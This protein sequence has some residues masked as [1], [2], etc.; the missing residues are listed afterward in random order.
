MSG[1]LSGFDANTVD[2]SRGYEPLPAGWYEACIVDS[3]LKRTKAGNGMYF[4]VEFQ[5]V[6]GPFLNRKVW[7]NINWENPNPDAKR[8]GRAQLSAI[9]RAVDVLTPNDFDQLHNKTMRVKVV[10]KKSDEYGDGNE[11]KAY[12]PRNAA[13]AQQQ[14]RT[15]N[16]PSWPAATE[17]PS[18]AYQETARQDE[19]VF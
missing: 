15:G 18:P 3:A 19:C 7:T 5:V 14:T 2:P 4:A 17:D 8:I 6:S 1:N 11:I 10:V 9:C 13:P 16:G 12:E